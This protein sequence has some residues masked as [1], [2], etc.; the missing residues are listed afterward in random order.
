MKLKDIYN[1]MKSWYWQEARKFKYKVFFLKDLLISIPVIIIYFFVNRTLHVNI[2]QLYN[3][4]FASFSTALA[5]ILAGLPLLLNI[6]KEPVFI[7]IKEKYGKMI[8]WVYKYASITIFICIILLGFG[9]LEV[10]EYAC[11]SVY[12]IA[13]L[14]HQCL[15]VLVLSVS[16][17]AIMR[18]FYLLFQCADRLLQEKGKE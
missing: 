15:I 11:S 1:A 9:M 5:F 14:V 4:L 8:V 10:K 16:T 17:L 6:L 7:T 2:S 13:K 3:A 12:R 18:C